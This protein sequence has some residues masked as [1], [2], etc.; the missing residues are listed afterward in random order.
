MNG[1][2]L[3]GAGV[4]LGVASATVGAATKDK[5]GSYPNR[6]VRFI[7]PFAP[8]GP[9][10]I[11]S[12]LVGQKLGENISQTIVVDNRGSV[13]GLLGFEAGAKAA[14][15]GYT[16]LMS[17]NSLLTINPHVYKKLP[18]DPKKDLQPISQL[19]STGNVF[20]V[21]PS[22]GAKTV[23]ELIALAKAR[24]GALNYASSGNGSTVQ[25]ASEMFKTMA[26]VNL[27][28]VPFNGSAP[29]VVQTVGFTRSHR[30]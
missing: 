17:A 23:Q 12:R 16:L 22:V 25:L 30:R 10:D 29:A 15:D 6:P 2:A 21:H 9:S 24:P 27:R 19:T 11:L 1:L 7:V 4:V 3:L 14:P 20:V 18:Y 26:G 5:E 13:G 8:G 28:H